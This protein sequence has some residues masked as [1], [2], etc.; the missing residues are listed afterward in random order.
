MIFWRLGQA[1]KMKHVADARPAFAQS[2][3]HFVIKALGQGRTGLLNSLGLP[4]LRTSKSLIMA[5]HAPVQW[6]QCTMCDWKMPGFTR[7]SLRL[8]GVKSL[9][10]RD[11]GGAVLPCVGGCKLV[12]G[13]AL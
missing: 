12:T 1:S 11:P 3:Q 10:P 6:H 13:K 4:L 8:Y 9:R 2:L 5:G 7:Y